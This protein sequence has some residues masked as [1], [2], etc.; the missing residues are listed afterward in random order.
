M[1]FLVGAHDPCRNGRP[2]KFKVMRCKRGNED[3]L[4]TLVVLGTLLAWQLGLELYEPLLFEDPRGAPKRTGSQNRT[5]LS[6]LTVRHR[7]FVRGGGK[8]GARATKNS[9]EHY[10]PSSAFPGPPSGSSKGVKTRH[11]L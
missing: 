5:S 1:V 9:K 7:D 2:H 6:Y 10:L 4:S 11:F 8:T 3:C